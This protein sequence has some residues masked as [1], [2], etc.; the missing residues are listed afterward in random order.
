M[1]CH[2]VPC[3]AIV[4]AKDRFTAGALWRCLES[5]SLPRASRVSRASCSQ[6]S[7]MLMRTLADGRRPGSGAECGEPHRRS[8][9]GIGGDSQ[10]SGSMLRCGQELGPGKDQPVC[11]GLRSEASDFHPGWFSAFRSRSLSN[12]CRSSPRRQTRLGKER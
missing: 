1:L 10:S 2:V 6:V 11:R 9:G 7:R 5:A 4:P 8:R 12:S 3:C